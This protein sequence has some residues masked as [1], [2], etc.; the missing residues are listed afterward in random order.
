MRNILVT[1]G[2]GYIG[3]VLI[4]KLIKKHNVTVL[5]IGWFGNHLN[6]DTNIVIGDIRN[7]KIVNKIIKDIDVVIHLASISNDPCAELNYK[8]TEDI[9][10]NGT[11][12]LLKIAKKNDVKRF[13]NISTGSVYGIKNE[14][15]VTE[16][17]PLEPLTIY[18]KTKADTEQ[19]VKKYNDDDF[20]TVNIRP[21]TTCGYSPRM[22]F[23]LVVNILTINALINKEIIVYGGEQKRPVIHIDDLTD[24]Y[25]SIIDCPKN[26]IN[27]EVFNVNFENLSVMKMAYMIADFL[28]RN[29]GIVIKPIKDMRSYHMSSEKVVKILGFKPKKTISDAIIDIKNAYDNNLINDYKNSI[30][31][32]I[33]RMKELQVV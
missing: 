12:N 9:N 13:I 32:N 18:S 17:L 7:K 19:I 4:P 20:T 16:N 27:G 31:Y 2:L 6:V 22:R 11:V 30:Y 1:G 23:D 26:K 28:G 29:I 14:L 24:F 33:K 25:L 15:F 21:S 3:S 5:D 8:L 10:Y